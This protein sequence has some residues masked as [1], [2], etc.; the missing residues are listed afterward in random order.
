MKKT[1]KKD[2]WI[3]INQRAITESC[4][5]LTHKRVTWIALSLEDFELLKAFSRQAWNESIRPVSDVKNR[6]NSLTR[7][8]HKSHY[9]AVKVTLHETPK[10]VAVAPRWR[11]II[12]GKHNT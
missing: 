2:L 10:F 9:E 4:V 8:L 6:I 11:E 3:E 1:I 12:E 7:Q 5:V